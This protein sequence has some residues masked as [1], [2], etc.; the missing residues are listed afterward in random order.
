MALLMKST[1]TKLSFTTTPASA[2]SPNI[3]TIVMSMPMAMCPQMAPTIPNGMAAMMISGWTYE[4][5]GIASRAKMS[6][7]ESRN[8][9]CNPPTASACSAWAPWNE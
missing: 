7:M 9:C 8:P 5:N 3:D 1:M 4:R 6:S 2:T